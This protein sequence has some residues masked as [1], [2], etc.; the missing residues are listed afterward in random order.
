[1]LVYHVDVVL[2]GELPAA[3]VVAALEE[4]AYGAA[5]CDLGVLGLDGFDEFDVAHGKGIGDDVLVAYAKVFEIEGFGVTGLGTEAGPLAGLGVAIGPFDEVE[6]VLFVLLK[7][8]PE[9][10]TILLSA[11]EHRVNGAVLAG[12]GSSY[13]GQRFGAEVFAELE[14]FVVAEAACLV[15]APKVAL[16]FAL[17]QGADGLFPVI[18]IAE[19]VAMDEAAAGESHEAGM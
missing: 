15:V 10:N 16:R 19:A 6:Y 7:S 18:H 12:H 4:G 2:L 8:G 11:A 14:E 13:Y 1:M 17:M 9:G 5:D 3:L